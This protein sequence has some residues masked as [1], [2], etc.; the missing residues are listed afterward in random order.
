M[1]DEVNNQ[2][3]TDPA[4]EALQDLLASLPEC[5]HCHEPATKRVVGAPGWLMCDTHDAH[6]PRFETKDLKS[7]PAIRQAVAVLRGDA[8][9]I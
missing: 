1:A 5:Q 7:A 3:K 6:E 9:G 4:L 8:A 2:L